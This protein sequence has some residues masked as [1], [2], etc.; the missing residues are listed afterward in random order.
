MYCSHVM[1]CPPSILYMQRLALVLQQAM[2]LAVTME[3]ALESPNLLSATVTL[4][5]KSLVTAVMT[6]LTSVD[7]RYY[8]YF[9][10][11]GIK[12]LHV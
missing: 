9:E 2:T 10:M 1:L 6:T 8:M 4:S 3:C 12:C 5:V 11:L 7:V